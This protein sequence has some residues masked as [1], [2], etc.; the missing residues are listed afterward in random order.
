MRNLYELERA[1]AEVLEKHLQQWMAA[2]I[3]PAEKTEPTQKD[4]EI[5]KSLGYIK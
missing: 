5:L 3:E 4:L 1:R 2:Q